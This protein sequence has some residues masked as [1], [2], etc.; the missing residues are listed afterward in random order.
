VKV[1]TTD[2][3]ATPVVQ[4]VVEYAYDSMDRLIGRTV[5]GSLGGNAE[6]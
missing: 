1:T 5:D 6:R 4:K 3:A 2:N